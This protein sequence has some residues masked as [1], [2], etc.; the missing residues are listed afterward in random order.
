[1]NFKLSDTDMLTATTKAFV[2]Q[3]DDIKTL[4]GESHP[5]FSFEKAIEGKANFSAQFRQTLHDQLHLQY[6]AIAKKEHVD[7][8]VW[9]NI[10]LLKASN[11]FTVCSGQQLHLF[12]GPAFVIYKIL[13]LVDYCEALK[14]Q[15]PDKNFVPVY[16]LASEDH[17][18]DEIKNT[19]LFNQT[20]TWDAVPGDACGRL[21]T[22]SVKT[23]IE[24]IGRTVNLNEEQSKLL[25]EFDA[26]YSSS[27]NLGEA[28]IRVVNAF[29]GTYG[30]ICVN[31]DSK[32]FKQEFIPVIEQDLINQNNLTDFEEVSKTLLN[33]GLSTQL[34]ARQ[35][36]FFYLH[37]GQRQRIVLEDSVY[38][39]LDGSII[40]EAS[41]IK[42]HI[43]DFPERFSPNAMLRP[44]YQETILPNIAY[45][46]GNAE[47]TYW[48]Q[49]HKVMVNNK[50]SHPTLVLRPSV[51][52]SPQKTLQWLEKRHISPL[53]VLTSRSDEE[54]L[55]I[56]TGNVL[57]LSAE[58]TAFNELRSKIQNITAQN[59]G[60]ELKPLVEA[61]KA[62]EKHL[63]N[64]DKAIRE[65]GIAKSG[66]EFEKLKDIKLNLFNI[67][68][69]Q[70]RKL[71]ALEMLIKF[72]D[73]IFSVKNSTKLNNSDGHVICL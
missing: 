7:T 9:D 2:E 22:D 71:D 20:F 5:Y 26:I 51:W 4:L 10:E 34:N 47:I 36:N 41:A 43:A 29:M 24:A 37:N 62:Y 73:V 8:K 50:I 57:D 46:G 28:T 54:L 49:L 16:W 45:I 11:T 35:I 14:A 21:K 44:L 3:T 63:K 61:G 65:F 23:L 68:S 56:L 59:V 31:G 60:S 52:I 12:F 32:V 67:N 1:M 40:A 48:I 38:K 33:K 6:S 69:I 42:T 64:V 70:E 58:I 66:Q 25:A 13:A 53:Q 72:R 17:D 19:K 30:V 55:E 18:F 39:C 27:E 15:Y